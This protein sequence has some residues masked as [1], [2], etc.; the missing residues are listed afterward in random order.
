MYRKSEVNP[1]HEACKGEKMK[2]LQTT[3]KG[4]MKNRGRIL[5]RNRRAGLTLMETTL[6]TLIVGLSVLSIVRLVTAVTQQNFY[7]QKTTTAL[8]L[9]NNMRELLVGLSFNDPAFGTHLGP[10]VGE[11]TVAQFNDVQDFNG[12]VAN[13]PIDANRQPI[14]SMANWRQS[15]TVTHVLPGNNGYNSTD[16]SATDSAVVLDRVTVVVSY[17]ATPATS[18]NWTTITSI[19][20]LKSKY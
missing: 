20:W 4:H 14:T 13:P 19:E 9:A 12:Y 6:S 5:R 15:V 3:G 11:T 2:M 7:A 1:S 18:T 17:N 16:P 8:M 10:D